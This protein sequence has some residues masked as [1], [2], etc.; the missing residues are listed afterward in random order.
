MSDQPPLA[1]FLESHDL[2]HWFIG[3]CDC[4]YDSLPLLAHLACADSFEKNIVEDCNLAIDDVR[5]LRL[6]LLDCD[7]LSELHGDENAT[8]DTSAENVAEDMEGITAENAA[9]GTAAQNG[10]ARKLVVRFLDTST[11]VELEASDTIDSVQAKI[12]AKTGIPIE[13]QKLQ[14]NPLQHMVKMELTGFVPLKPD[15]MTEEELDELI[16]IMPMAAKFFGEN[17]HADRMEL[18]G[19][20]CEELSVHDFVR[21]LHFLAQPAD[22][23]FPFQAG[24]SSSTN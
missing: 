23:L 5:K 24:S 17:P 21:T 2:G 7:E 14:E 19:Y 11:C 3:L 9:E 13:H 1:S 16:E 22:S 18:Q 6:A 4:G 10:D 8:Q 12:R 20:S 15:D